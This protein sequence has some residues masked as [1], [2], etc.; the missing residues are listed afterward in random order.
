MLEYLEEGVCWLCSRVQGILANR[1]MKG[2]E[3]LKL[4]WSQWVL[5]VPRMA[6]FSGR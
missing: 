5:G 4:S 3:Q 6:L 1:V 2:K